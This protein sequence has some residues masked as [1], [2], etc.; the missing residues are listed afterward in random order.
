M[1]AH[2]NIGTKGLQNQG[3]QARTLVQQLTY[4]AML[5]PTSVVMVMAQVSTCT[6]V[7]QQLQT[8]RNCEHIVL[9]IKRS[10]FNRSSNVCYEIWF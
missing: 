8:C 10:R 7:Q 2:Y 9:C 3:H 6:E 5:C 4:T 1:L